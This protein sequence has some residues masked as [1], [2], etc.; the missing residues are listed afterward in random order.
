MELEDGAIPLVNTTASS[1]ESTS[2]ETIAYH[3]VDR[4]LGT[5]F[6]TIE[7]DAENGPTYFSFRI[8][9]PPSD[10]FIHEVVINLLFLEDWFYF[11]D[12]HCLTSQSA[13]RV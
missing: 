2:F 9:L 12:H 13:Y 10:I 3:A 1:S 8:Y 7:H 4:D 5:F 6:E 11:P